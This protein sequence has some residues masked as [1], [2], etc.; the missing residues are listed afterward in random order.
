MPATGILTY[1]DEAGTATNINLSTMIANFET[2]TS[3]SQNNA[4]GTITY[5]DE[6]GVSTVL[7]IAALIATNETLTILSISG[8]NL[9]YQDENG[10]TTAI[11]LSTINANDWHTNGNTGTTATNFL[12]TTDNQPLRVRTN[13]TEHW[14][15][16][17][18]GGID[19]QTG[20]TIAIGK[21]ALMTNLNTS[22]AYRNTAIGYEALR[23]NTSG[24]EN[25]LY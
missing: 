4:A 18:D 25:T 7:N 2:L 24:N 12:G 5:V 11:L 8:G 15:F 13:N 22:I 6:N 14:V 9:N 19:V 3:I 20:T 21:D 16:R 1:N 10:T 23:L 17:T